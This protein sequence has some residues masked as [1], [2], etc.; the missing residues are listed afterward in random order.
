MVGAGMSKNSRPLPGVRTTFPS[1]DELSRAMFDEIYTL[2]LDATE[3][4]LEDRERKFNQKSALRIASEYEARFKRRQLDEFLLRSI[5][6][7]DHQPGRL[8]ELLLDL[9]WKDVFTTNFDTLLERTHVHGRS[10]QSVRAIDD[11]ATSASPRIIKLHG[12]FFSSTSFII[13]EEDYRTYPQK[14]AP[15]VNTVR[16]SLIEN[17]FVLIGFSGDDPNFLEWIGWI[18]DELSNRQ[19]PIYLVGLLEFTDVDRALLEHRGVT[20]IDLTPISKEV[21]ANDQKHSTTLEW[22]LRG[23]QTVEPPR[24]ERWP[25]FT[26]REQTVTGISVPVLVDKVVEP[27]TVRALVDS[28]TTFDEITAIKIIVRWRHER[29]KYP[30]WLVLTDQKRSSLRQETMRYIPRLISLARNWS[31]VDQVLLFREMIWRIETSMLPLDVSLMEPLETACDG[32]F[33][34]LT[35]GSR[36]RPSDKM[37]ELLSVTDTEVQEC[38]LEIAFA[39]IRDSRESFE[40]TSWNTLNGKVSQVIHLF[41]Q[42]NDRFHY[43]HALWNLWNLERSEARNL[44]SQWV[45]SP[46]SP[47]ALMWKAGL[48]I[49]LDDLS[50]SR[51]LLRLAL[52]E[53][54]QSFHRTQGA[55][56]DLLS[57]EGWCTYLLMPVESEINFRNLHQ[58][59]QYQNYNANIAGVHEQFLKRWDQLKA[60]DSDPW[61]FVEYFERVLSGEPPATQ[62]VEQVVPG[63]DIGHYTVK[64]SLFQGPNT[65]WL[66]AFSYLRML[67]R[68]GIPPR[69][70]NDTVRNV[71]K[72]LAP[73][74]DFWS[75]MLLVRAG[76]TRAVREGDIANRA[77]IANMSPDLVRSLNSW[78]MNALSRE[79]SSLGGPI[80]MQSAQVS[81]LE[82]LIEF[83]SRLTLRL[84]QDER[85]DAFH[86]ALKLHDLPGIKTHI[87]LNR[88]C[89]AWFRRLFDSADG[90]Q[91]LEWLPELIRFSL[92]NDASENNSSQHPA[93]SWPDPMTE[94]PVDTV[95]EIQKVGPNLKAEI[96]EAIEWLLHDT[97]ATSGEKR[98]RALMRLFR[99]F[100]TRIMTEEQEKHFGE[101]LWEQSIESGLPDLPDST[102]LNYLHTPSPPEINPASRIKQHLLTLKPYKSVSFEGS[103]ISINSPGESEDQM[104][105]EISIASRPVVLLPSET[106]GEIDWEL[107]EVNQMWNDVYKW[108]ENDKHAIKH[109]NNNPGL[110]SGFEEFARR[111]IDRVSM[112]LSRVVLPQME[113]A[114]EED[115]DRILSFLSEARQ[116]KVFLSQALPYILLHRPSELNMVQKTIRDALTSGGEKAVIAAAEA[117]SHWAY[118]GDEADVERV[119]QDAINDL[120]KRVVFRRPEGAK[121]CLRQLSIIIS[122][123]SDLID[124]D[125]VHLV[126]S[127]LTPWLEATLIPIPEND[128]GGFPEHERPLL[129]T[130]LGQLASALSDWMKIILPGQPEPPEISSLRESYSSHPLPEV[131]RSFSNS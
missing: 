48:L 50:E 65:K 3:K 90:Q 74:S 10:Y 24:P 84:G 58:D 125:Q 63:F 130:R 87:R 21:A 88:S 79:L 121:T 129:R 120:I 32:L 72:W 23:L 44:L 89:G 9:P 1:W 105:H 16:Q 12:P 123:K 91:L 51:S 103:S 36:L 35:D 22:F 25:D 93:I 109:V 67:E 95:R 73:I 45:P 111:S 57:L 131:R 7:D 61:P 97:Q 42:Y 53:I 94:F 127:S 20:P 38:W 49:E 68:V 85:Q 81:L 106:Q 55:N 56:I 39:L 80:P 70:V 82:T 107:T 19:A 104:I 52:E 54:R 31:H 117:V 118:L 76:N 6:N 92:P 34:S 2:P 15:F 83:L 26:L 40:A 96:H 110:T 114:N 41:P 112:F 124:S 75:T 116:D 43:E 62:K 59:S 115:W 86:M 18:R 8:H 33:S 4:H 71:A 126:V 27:K 101:L 69:F 30:G 128:R 100:H 5:P 99:V 98:Q 17:A 78:A 77:Q 64:R 60:W 108:W 102:L 28:Q 29:L 14:F 122:K 47:L 113:T 37:T 119:P 66:P 11:L 46:Y 13:T